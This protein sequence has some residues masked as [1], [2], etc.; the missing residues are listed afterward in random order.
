[1]RVLNLTALWTWTNPRGEVCVNLADYTA[2]PL[3]SSDICVCV[4]VSLCLHQRDYV[5]ANN[6]SVSVYVLFC[7]VHP[8][9][10]YNP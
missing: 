4:T 5:S 6:V 8:G 10:F 3:P 2:L 9:P 7:C 1:M